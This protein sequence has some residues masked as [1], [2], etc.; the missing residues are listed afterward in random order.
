MG[1]VFTAEYSSA[2]QNCDERIEAG[3][4]ARMVDV[5]EAV[6]ATCPRPRLP[7]RPVCPHCFIVHAVTQEDCDG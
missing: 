1:P 5:G 7:P 3:D 2:C 6:H 4:D